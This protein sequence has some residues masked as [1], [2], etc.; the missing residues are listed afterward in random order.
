MLKFIND[1][2]DRPVMSLQSGQRITST[3]DVLIDPRNLTV[4]GLYCE[5][6]VSGSDKILLIDDIREIG[7]LGI[8]VDSDESIS[9]ASD[10]IRLQE[11]IDIG[12]DPIGKNIITQ[13][14]QKLGK[15]DDYAIDD[16]SFKIEKFYG[17][18]SVLKS[19]NTNDYIINRRQVSSVNRD[20]VIVKDSFVES[21]KSTAKP[22]FS[23]IG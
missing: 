13:S 3:T 21:S 2:L 10:L 23:P 20:E 7:K 6:R 17:K 16:I 12:F 9:E 22:S 18:P 11:I 19:L 1:Y 15:I 5:D 4:A 14:G 8:I